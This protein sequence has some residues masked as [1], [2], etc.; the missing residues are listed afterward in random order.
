MASHPRGPRPQCRARRLRTVLLGLFLAASLA[1]CVSMPSGGPVV[2]Y[3]ITQGTT[4]QSQPYL[5]AI[6]EPPQP[7]WQPA[8][9]VRGFLAASA[10]FARQDIAREYLTA[11]EKSHWRPGWTAVVYSR[12]PNTSSDVIYAGTGAKRTATVTV[13]G[14]VQATLSGKG[15]YAVPSS[16][17]AAGPQTFTLQLVGGH[18]RISSAP[19]NL[20]L[21]SYQFQADYQPRNLYFFDSS[22]S[23]LVPDP[24]YVPTQGTTANLMGGLVN[25]LIN[26][27]RD[28]LTRGATN[29]YFPPHT[30]TIGDVTVN[31]GTAAVNLTGGIARDRNDNVLQHVSAQLLWT[32]TGSA[33]SGSAVQ[34][35]E[36]SLNGKPWSP[37]GIDQNP[38]QQLHQSRFSPPNGASSTYY[39]V[40]AAGNLFSSVGPQAKAQKLSH[41][42]TGYSQ[43]AVSPDNRY[44]AAVNNGLLFVGRI[45]G[46]LVQWSGSGYTSIS[47]DW[48]DQLWTT[49]EGQIYMVRG[50]ANPAQQAG[51]PILVN[52]VDSDGTT[53][54]NGPFADLRVAPDGARMALTDGMN[55]L[56]FGAIVTKPNSGGRPSQLNI[57]VMLS[58]FSVSVTGATFTSLAWYGADNVITLHDPGPQLTEYPVDGASSTSIPPQASMN[59]ITAS[60]GSA[61]LAGLPKDAMASDA[62]LTGSWLKLNQTASSAV[63]PG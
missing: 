27:P 46:P 51:K 6:P 19:S 30:S 8:D 57:Q 36:L 63:Y 47:W 48:L 56:Y 41:I 62:S 59:W 20:L 7:D 45:G 55:D 5:Q 34:S 42:G 49:S 33:G 39:Y 2:S 13:G 10:S 61:L 60:W 12:G 17:A 22:E 44:L 43:I 54:N 50:T 52:V 4:G 14:T 31:G 25:D 38:V 24:V 15:G 23:F 1:G 21:T 32:L 3:P 26:P 37:L 53:P 35:V 11:S 9:I 29:T 18:W 58:P 28:W 40:D 16:S